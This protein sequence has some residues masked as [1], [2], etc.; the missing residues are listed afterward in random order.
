M[1][2]PLN[3]DL[4]N[5]CETERSISGHA[6][7]QSVGRCCCAQN[8]YPSCCSHQS[9]IMSLSIERVWYSK[10]AVGKECAHALVP[11]LSMISVEKHA[12]W[13][14]CPDPFDSHPEHFAIHQD[15]TTQ[16]R[17]HLSNRCWRGVASRSHSSNEQIVRNTAPMIQR[18]Q[19]S[20]IWSK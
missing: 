9:W 18:Q 11:M 2:Y 10:H 1:I 5:I 16:W 17:C 3:H 13:K 7:R 4:D 8:R 15:N 20:C 12:L 14:T 19:V 6:I